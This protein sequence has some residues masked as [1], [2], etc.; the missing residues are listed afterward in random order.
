MS[1][2]LDRI[3]KLPRYVRILATNG[4]DENNAIVDNDNKD[5]KRKRHQHDYYIRNKRRWLDYYH[6]YYKINRVSIRAKKKIYNDRNKEQIKEYR[7]K[8]WLD[9]KERLKLKKREY[10]KRKNGTLS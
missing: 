7:K 1:S 10:H 8:Y 4:I 5:K 9:N 3:A 6:N 2:V